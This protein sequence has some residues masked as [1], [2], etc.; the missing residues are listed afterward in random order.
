MHL[1]IDELLAYTDEERGKWEQWFAAHGNEPLKLSVPMDVHPNIGALIIHCLWAELF[2]AH[3]MRGDVLTPERMKA[4][5]DSL[6]A[7]QADQVFAFGHAERKA[8]REAISEYTEKDWEKTHEVEGPGFRLEGSARKLIAHILVHE[9]RHW[10]Q[11]AVTVRQHGLAPPGE[12]D[13]LFS[14]S[15]GPLVRK[16]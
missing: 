16:I 9:I 4:I 5:N 10:A 8:L 1:T 7:D 15:F 14:Q 13:L 12:H 3:W 6:A 2:Y 11:V